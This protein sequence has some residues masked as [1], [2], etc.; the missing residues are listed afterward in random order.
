[1]QD[2]ALDTRGEIFPN[3]VTGEPV[4][5]EEVEDYVRTQTRYGAR[6]SPVCQ[7]LCLSLKLS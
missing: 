5:M 1:M 7:P 6:S 2:D 3:V 4:R